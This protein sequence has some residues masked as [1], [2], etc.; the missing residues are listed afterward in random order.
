MNGRQ[1]DIGPRSIR[2]FAPLRG[3]ATKVRFIIHPLSLICTNA[4]T[5]S[6]RLEEV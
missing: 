2:Y 4:L 5:P 6:Y 1:C 3:A